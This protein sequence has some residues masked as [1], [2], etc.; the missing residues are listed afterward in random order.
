MSLNQSVIPRRLAQPHGSYYNAV[1]SPNIVLLRRNGGR[2]RSTSGTESQQLKKVQ[3]DLGIGGN[4]QAAANVIRRLNENLKF[5]ANDEVFDIR[6][7]EPLVSS[8]TESGFSP[9]GRGFVYSSLNGYHSTI[10]G[11]TDPNEILYASDMKFAGICQSDFTSANAALQQQGLSVMNG[12]VKTILNDCGET[13]HMG[14]KLMLCV[15]DVQS[16]RRGVPN[17]KV[18]IALKPVPKDYVSRTIRERMLD[19]VTKAKNPNGSNKFT[20]AEI[21]D[22][23]DIADMIPYMITAFRKS[24]DLVVAKACSSARPNHQVDIKITAPTF[25]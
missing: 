8:K 7:G 22:W 1:L 24:A 3:R 20:I 14:D 9:H 10:P 19:A 6:A 15:P 23:S 5:T 17:E 12:G 2:Y 21:N 25:L 11:V 13:I 16:N 4:N 18:R